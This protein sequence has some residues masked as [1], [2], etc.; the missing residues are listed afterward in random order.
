MHHQLACATSSTQRDSPPSSSSRLPPLPPSAILP[1][2]S[3]FIAPHSSLSPLDGK[4]EAGHQSGNDTTT[5]PMKPSR[6]T[7][8]SPNATPQF[9]VSEAAS[10]GA[11]GCGSQD[12]SNS[13]HCH[14]GCELL[15]TCCFDFSVTCQHVGQDGPTAAV[16][17]NSTPC[18]LHGCTSG[19]V[20][21][22]GCQCHPR[23][24]DSQDCC[25][26][27]EAMCVTN[28]TT[29][30]A[31]AAEN[32]TSASTP[33]SGVRLTS[34]LNRSTRQAN[35]TFQHKATNFRAR[36]QEWHA[37]QQRGMTDTRRDVAIQAK[38]VFQTTS[39]R[40]SGMIA[41][42]SH[43]TRNGEAGLLMA[44]N[45]RSAISGG[46]LL[47]AGIGAGIALSVAYSAGWNAKVAYTVGW[48]MN[49]KSR[50]EEEKILL[51]LDEDSRETTQNSRDV[52]LP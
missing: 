30:L 49:N 43:A 34:V 17:T 45:T 41:H 38:T 18:A 24:Q 15:G 35:T 22:Y 8:T 14:K 6:V 16:L 44:Y 7:T 50:L 10:C 12:A 28:V 9:Q 13:C 19:L 31:T 48:D 40:D 23:C 4:L 42:S 46:V 25:P 11:Y 3:S 52:L 51:N 33:A 47:L 5:E 37:P 26:D 39:I 29:D 2:A 21:S 27:Y 1:P 36:S 20:V 32:L